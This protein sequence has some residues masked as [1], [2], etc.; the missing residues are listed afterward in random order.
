M[1]CRESPL[2]SRTEPCRPCRRLR[3][4]AQ[5]LCCPSGPLRRSAPAFPGRCRLISSSSLLLG[6]DLQIYLF[7]VVDDRNSQVDLRRARASL[8]PETGPVL[9]SALR[10]PRWRPCAGLHPPLRRALRGAPPARRSGLD[11]A[12]CFA[13]RCSSPT[14]V[15]PHLRRSS[16]RGPHSRVERAKADNLICRCHTAASAPRRSSP[17]QHP[18][19]YLICFL[20]ALITF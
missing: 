7:F 16:P 18:Q 2:P 8:A 5:V 20:L 1:I 9:S 3:A 17:R 15:S 11:L 4:R 14:A 10:P 13:N 12:I 19:L 6:L